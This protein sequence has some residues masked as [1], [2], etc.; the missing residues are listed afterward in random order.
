MC[1]EKIPHFYIK[2]LN[3]NKY[4]IYIYIISFCVGYFNVHFHWEEVNFLLEEKKSHKKNAH[5]F[6]PNSFFYMWKMAPKIL[7]NYFFNTTI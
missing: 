5:I 4:Y 7:I 1:L 2:K 3:P 6:F